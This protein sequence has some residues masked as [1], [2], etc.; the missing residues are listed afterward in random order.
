MKSNRVKPL[1]EG[2]EI[3]LELSKE[4]FINKINND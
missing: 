1:K 4:H 2:D 3:S